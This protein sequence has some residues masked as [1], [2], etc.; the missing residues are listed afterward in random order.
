MKAVA[1]EQ[2]NPL[3][4]S[5]M[6][7]FTRVRGNR[8]L[9]GHAADAAI[10]KLIQMLGGDPDDDVLSIHFGSGGSAESV[11]ESNGGNNLV[12]VVMS[13]GFL[14]T[15]NSIYNYGQGISNASGLRNISFT[16]ANSS[17]FNSDINALSKI[18]LG[19][20]LLTAIELSGHKFNVTDGKKASD[21]MITGSSGEITGKTD[22][23]NDG[24]SIIVSYNH[25]IFI[26][27]DGV[28]FKG[29]IALAHELFHGL[30]L[31]T[32]KFNMP[33]LVMPHKN[34]HLA[35]TSEFRQKSTELFGWDEGCSGR[36]NK[37]VG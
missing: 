37:S 4:N 8:D 30:D 27:A 5:L 13:E 11:F 32:S 25:Y 12:S 24:T 35:L 31:I 9:G 14:A 15:F 16:G 28:S 1:A 2:I 36:T 21:I 23:S 26:E 6:T 20:Y 29:Y 7:E 18:F 19:A 22:F 10:G 3:G 17:E 33:N 34:N